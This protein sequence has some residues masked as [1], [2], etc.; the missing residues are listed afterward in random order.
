MESSAPR[1]AFDYLTCS[2]PPECVDALHGCYL[3]FNIHSFYWQMTSEE[4]VQKV[5]NPIVISLRQNML[6]E[7]RQAFMLY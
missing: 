2:V 1:I 7:Q 3:Y 5:A 6:V 4:F